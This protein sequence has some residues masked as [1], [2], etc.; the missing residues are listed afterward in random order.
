MAGIFSRNNNQAEDPEELKENAEDSEELEENAEDPE[1][2]EENQEEELDK[3]EQLQDAIENFDMDA[4]EE[5]G[6][7]KK[8]K[9]VRDLKKKVQKAG[10]IGLRKLLK[11]SLYITEEEQ[12]SED[13]PKIAQDIEISGRW[14]LQ[15]RERIAIR[16]AKKHKRLK[17]LVK[18][19]QL[20][21]AKNIPPFVSKVGHAIVPALPWILIVALIFLVAIATFAAFVVVLGKLGFQPYK[22]WLKDLGVEVG[23]S[24]GADSPFGGKGDKFYG[25][26]T[27]YK[28]DEKASNELVTEYVDLITQANSILVSTNIMV[29]E[30][31]DEKTY[32]VQTQIDVEI[33]E[34]YNYLLD[35]TDFKTNH[36]KLFNFV[37]G[38]ATL[39]FEKDNPTQAVP[40]TLLEKLNGIKYFGLTENLLGDWETNNTVLNLINNLGYTYTATLNTVPVEEKSNELDAAVLDYFE[41]KKESISALLKQNNQIRTEKLFVKDY[42]YEDANKGM[43]GVGIENYVAFIF[44]PKEDLVITKLSFMFSK[45]DENFS[46]TLSYNEQDLGLQ[47]DSKFGNDDMAIS[48]STEEEIDEAY[49]YYTNEMSLSVS[50]FE[51]ISSTKLDLLKDGVSLSELIK[52]ANENSV[53]YTIYLTTKTDENTNEFLTLKTNGIVLEMQNSTPFV[54][55]EFETLCN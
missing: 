45:I 42:I 13:L 27:V 1:E 55:V 36:E 15:S 29:V 54:A 25:M 34:N 52:L 10:G 33:P 18:K 2:S 37:D 38:V 26:R 8:L 50:K 14:R 44:M 6:I 21:L 31:G 28:D 47:F 41:S 51:D 3:I 20:A 53:D 40:E 49:I 11:L 4:F 30:G 22:Q 43:E 5:A 48:G 32:E 46:E 24:S 9:M 39:V 17:L 23:S 16:K 12:L 35:E 7:L 19:I